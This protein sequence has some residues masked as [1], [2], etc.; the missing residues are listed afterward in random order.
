MTVIESGLVLKSKLKFVK[1]DNLLG[2][3]FMVYL[4]FKFLIHN[5]QQVYYGQK[6]SIQKL[7]LSVYISIYNARLSNVYLFTTLE[8][9]FYIQY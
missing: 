5:D 7:S 4:H 2:F 8:L 9:S 6:L 3:R 1:E